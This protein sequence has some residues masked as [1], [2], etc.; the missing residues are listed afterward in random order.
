MAKHL[1]K[2][3]LLEACFDLEEI[4]KFIDAHT[5]QFKKELTELVLKQLDERMV[6]PSNQLVD[7]L[8]NYLYG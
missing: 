6:K 4:S 1:T 7:G 8:L 3:E 5:E 2:E